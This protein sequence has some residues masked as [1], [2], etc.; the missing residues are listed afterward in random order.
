MTARVDGVTQIY[1]SEVFGAAVVHR[2][3]PGIGQPLWSCALGTTTTVNC[4]AVD[5]DG[6]VYVAGQFMEALALCDGS[7]L[8]HTGSGLD[9]DLFLIKFDPAG[10]PLWKRN[11]SIA[12]PNAT[13]MA[14]LAIDP[15]G[16]L[17]YATSDF[18]LT[19]I[20][21]VDASGNDVEIRTIDGGKTIGGM[22]FDPW[23]GCT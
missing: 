3:D 8:G 15:N 9:V 6:N 18:M 7:T 16:D 1:G 10:M 4:G 11:I 5:D 14:A 12:Q 19:H 17:W 20:N 22:S 21:R 13:M 23:A 2:L